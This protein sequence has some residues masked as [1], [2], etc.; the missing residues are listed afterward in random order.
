MPH[1]IVNDM[2]N[3]SSNYPPTRLRVLCMSRRI[4][5]GKLAEQTGI[6]LSTLVR[7]E[8]GIPASPWTA[9]ALEATFGL[10]IDALQARV[11]AA[12]SLRATPKWPASAARSRGSK[13]I[14]LTICICSSCKRWLAFSQSRSHHHQPRLARSA[15]I[16]E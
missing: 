16:V 14:V 5:R 12:T 2:M 4:S 7:I 15:A 13:S 9:R 11:E 10:T 8:H 3:S 6:S 1:G